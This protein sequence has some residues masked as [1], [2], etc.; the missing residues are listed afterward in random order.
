MGGQR[1]VLRASFS[2]FQGL[3]PAA[4]LKLWQ[5][6]C[7][8]WKAFGVLPIKTFSPKKQ[9]RVAREIQVAEKAL[10]AGMPDFFLN[11]FSC[12]LKPRVL[13]DF[14]EQ[15]VFLDIETTGLA[16][17]D[18]ITTIAVLVNGKM[19]VFAAGAD[20]EQVLPSLAHAK[21]LVTYNGARFDVPF[22]RRYFGIDLATP[23]LDLMPVLA[24]SG[25]NGGQKSCENLCDLKRRFSQGVDGKA[26]VRLWSQYRKDGNR[27]ALR[28]LILYN[29]ED[30][31]MLEKLAVI[32]Y[33]L[34]MQGY[35]HTLRIEPTFPL[36]WT[37]GNIQ[38]NAL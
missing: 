19:S 1:T 37:P 36:N 13:R 29:A 23:H 21:L 27:D 7:L 25:Y 18:Q 28:K 2:C 20:L 35:P 10:A 17:Q 30:V 12:T 16:K 9:E 38:T 11:Q 4:E 33:K 32:A 34:S 15:T 3:S 5:A 8:D 6:G 24:A 26:A 22:I 14:Y 31:V